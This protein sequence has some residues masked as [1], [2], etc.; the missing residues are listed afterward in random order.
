MYRAT[1]E[2]LISSAGTHQPL[3]KLL[4]PARVGSGTSGLRTLPFWRRGLDMTRI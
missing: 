2:L 3:P 4:F 1:A